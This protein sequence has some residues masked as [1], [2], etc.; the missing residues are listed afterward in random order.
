MGLAERRAAKKFETDVFPAILK[1]V[2]EAA[3]FVLPIDVHWDQLCADGYATMYEEAWSKVFFLPLVRALKA[4][5]IDDIGRTALQAG[6]RSVVVVNQGGV[7]YADAMATLREGVLTLDH[8]PC[9]NID[10]VDDR[11][12]AIQAVL[13]A[14]L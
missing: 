3:G 9:T 10:D 1:Q 6:L 11:A 4:I 14:G 7:Y 12:K 8:E 2:E 13:E 5:T